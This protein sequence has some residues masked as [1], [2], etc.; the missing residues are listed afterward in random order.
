MTQTASL[1]LPLLRHCFSYAQESPEPGLIDRRQWGPKQA[2]A[3]SPHWTICRIGGA[4]QPGNG[5]MKCLTVSALS[6]LGVC[7][8][9]GM[10]Y[11][12]RPSLSP[13]SLTCHL[14][15]HLS[16]SHYLLRSIPSFAI[17]L[18]SNS[19]HPPPAKLESSPMTA[20]SIHL[21]QTPH[22]LSMLTQQGSTS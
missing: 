4:A 5:D 8:R 1:A 21:V 7:T 16:R 18:A 9:G 12:L 19:L 14:C 11:G 2:E 22:N 3:P 13:H 15:G 10:T 17:M 20:L 6:C